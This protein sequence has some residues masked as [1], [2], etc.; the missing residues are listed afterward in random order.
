V[1]ST[2]D[3][4][5]GGVSISSTIREIVP[6]TRLVWSGQA[7]G[8]RAIH[9]W[10]LEETPDGVMVTTSE[11]FDGWMARLLTKMMQANLDRVLISWLA[12]LKTE[13]QGRTSVLLLGSIPTMRANTKPPPTLVFIPCFSGA[14]W[15]SNQLSH[16]YDWP[17]RTLRLPD[18]H[19]SLDKYAEFVIE[20]IK[21]L[22]HYVLVGDSFGAVVSIA[23]AVRQPAGLKGLIL[24]GGFAKNPITSP[25][26]KLLAAMAPFFPGVLYR[27]LT[28]RAHAS[29]LRSRFD[30]EGE[31]P[32][33]MS[34]TQKYF[35]DNTPHPAYVNR[36]AAVSRADYLSRLR[37]INVPA[38]IL[39]PEEDRLIGRN[40][41]EEMLNG[42]K[43]ACELILPRTGHMF[44]FSHPRLYSRA[45]RRFLDERVTEYDGGEILDQHTSLVS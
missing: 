15:E 43:G 21:D 24:S 2:F 26:L 30:G 16:L 19:D 45:M 6:M 33:S 5:S 31:V 4:K 3:W 28:L 12:A 34:K 39:T 17:S 7:I 29:N 14:T 13:A 42:I 10:E 38:L 20:Q 35:V 44:R 25:V 8:I 11:S 23:I 36:V 40:A 27:Q 41:A 18:V 32:W 9:V 22:E 37:D 1:G